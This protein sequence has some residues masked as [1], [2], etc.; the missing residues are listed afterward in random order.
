MLMS[1]DMKLW[2]FKADVIRRT[3][4]APFFYESDLAN[5]QFVRIWL[6]LAYGAVYNEQPAN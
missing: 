4:M 5:D 1:S 2:K 6:L 3:K